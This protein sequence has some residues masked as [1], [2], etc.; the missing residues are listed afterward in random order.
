MSTTRSHRRLRRSPPSPPPPPPPPPPAHILALPTEVL[1]ECIEQVPLLDPSNRVRPLI[2]LS[3]ICRLWRTTLL[4]AKC[5]W[6]RFAFTLPRHVQPVLFELMKRAYPVPMDLTI[7]V[8]MRSL[9]DGTEEDVAKMDALPAGLFADKVRVRNL[10]LRVSIDDDASRIKKVVGLLG[11]NAFSDLKSLHIER[12]TR[13]SGTEP[14]DGVVALDAFSTLA[15]RLGNLYVCHLLWSGWPCSPLVNLTV[16]ELDWSTQYHGAEEWRKL[17]LCQNLKQLCLHI[18]WEWSPIDHDYAEVTFSRLQKLVVH[19]T[20]RS[21]SSQVGAELFD[22]IA[23]PSLRVL[24]FHTPNGCNWPFRDAIL[25]SERTFPHV[26]SL[27]IDWDHTSTDLSP[28]FPALYELLI[29]PSYGDTKSVMNRV[30]GA[31]IGGWPRCRVL[32]LRENACI[33]CVR[34]ELTKKRNAGKPKLK[35]ILPTWAPEW[36]KEQGFWQWLSEKALVT[37]SGMKY[38]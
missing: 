12:I 18:R 3:S 37:V 14:K 19:C 23:C 26:K 30:Q 25:E 7:T 13:R 4:S 6:R 22:L 15:P 32:D 21:A 31:L 28:Y 11:S 36:C 38:L 27:R 8:W 29:T 20:G 2:L 1:V 9:W 33:R 16:L 10:R 5:L 34:D 17:S 24:H 35:L